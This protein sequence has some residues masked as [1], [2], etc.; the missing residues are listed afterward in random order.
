[1]TNPASNWQTAGE[2]RPTKNFLV[3]GPRGCGKSSFIEVA[4]DGKFK[5]SPSK[6]SNPSTEFRSSP[7]CQIGDQI[8][9]FIECPGFG[10]PSDV[11]DTLFKLIKYLDRSFRQ[12]LPL[13]LTGILYIHPESDDLGSQTLRQNLRLLRALIGEEYSERVTTLL[14]SRNENGEPEDLETKRNSLL[15]LG[16]PF[17]SFYHGISEP[18]VLAYKLDQQSIGEITNSYSS[19]WARRFSA[20]DNIVNGAL[21]IEDIP[22]Y[23]RKELDGDQDNRPEGQGAAPSAP[24]TLEEVE[25]KEPTDL[26]HTQPEN[27]SQG[28]KVPMDSPRQDLDTSPQADSE[29]KEEGNREI[30]SAN[31]PKHSES[32]YEELIDKLNDKLEKTQAEYASLRSHL[33]VQDN[34]EHGQIT[35]GFDDIN[36]LIEDFGQLVSDHLVDD[37]P[38]IIPSINDLEAPRLQA[39]LGMFGHS[40]GKSSLVKSS[41]GKH[42]DLADF[43]FYAIRATV[44]NELYTHLFEPFH[45]SIAGRKHEQ[46][47][48]FMFEVYKQIIRQEPQSV[49]GRWRKDSFNSIS[50]TSF[51]SSQSTI[52]QHIT[53]SIC[54]LIGFFFNHPIV[55]LLTKEHE[56]MLDKLIAMAENWN[57]M[58]KGSVV[59]HGD[60]R[61][62]IYPYCGEF[63]SNRMSE[64]GAKPNDTNYPKASLAT[65]E[66]GLIKYYAVGQNQEPEETVL[67][68]V[69]IASE[70][71]LFR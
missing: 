23:L 54:I 38:D 10:D 3:L 51:A 68:K 6:D 28:D 19:F 62:I 58:V 56:Q 69:M 64:F 45:P 24:E 50:R 55:G 49:A 61:P 63:Q 11:Q 21:K 20:Q 47:N 22:E 34:I 26:V 37:C 12:A 9:K 1:M 14:V 60:F 27:E 39:L 40:E 33:Q 52:R 29:Q 31:A 18:Q 30:S 71:L 70:K 44:C 8:I 32:A 42:P 35:Q 46:Q 53:S 65:V 13:R 48:N 5:S 67:R 16:S 41:G 17:H 25:R 43:F 57:L 7:P 4:T 66:L 15:A 2:S 36:R 59:F